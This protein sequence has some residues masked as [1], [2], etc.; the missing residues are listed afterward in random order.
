[1]SGLFRAG[2]M[3]AIMGSSG[4]GKSTLLNVLSKRITVEGASIKANGRSYDFEEFGRFA[5]F[6]TQEDIF[7]PNLTVRETIQFAADLKLN[8]P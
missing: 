3:T 2:E 7:M 8:L 4:S 1:M 5:N 6:I